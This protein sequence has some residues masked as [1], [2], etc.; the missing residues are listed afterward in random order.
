MTYSFK[1]ITS[2][3]FQNLIKIHIKYKHQTFLSIEE[4]S[5][6]SDNWELKLISFFYKFE[7][8]QKDILKMNENKTRMP[9]S[10]NK[11]ALEDYLEIEIPI[12]QQ[13]SYLENIPAPM[14]ISKIYKYDENGTRTLI[15]YKKIADKIKD[16]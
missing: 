2:P 11:V 16:F 12:Q 14:N 4:L 6:S 8:L 13:N 1:E 5:F 15:K 7:K 9:S 3:E 10:I